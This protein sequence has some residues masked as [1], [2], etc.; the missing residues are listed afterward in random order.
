MADINRVELFG[1]F[2]NDAEFR[3][4]RS[5]REI[6]SFSLATDTGHFDKDKGGWQENLQWHKIVTFQKG[7]IAVL[8]DRGKKG[9]RVIVSGELT[10][11][12]WRKDGEA[13]DRRETEIVVGMDGGLNFVD[14][15]RDGAR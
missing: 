3:T 8:K 10:Y 11:L 1:R 6:A 14:R 13:T 2:G 15:D 4:T 7:L 9:V 5:G 12:T